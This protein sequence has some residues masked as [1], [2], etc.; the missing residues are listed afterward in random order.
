MTSNNYKNQLVKEAKQLD[1]L[2]GQGSKFDN[3]TRE[4]TDEQ[5]ERASLEL[6][7][8]LGIHVKKSIIPKI[9][10]RQN[11][12]IEL[13]YMYRGSK[14]IEELHQNLKEVS[15]I[16]LEDL[17]DELSEFIGLDNVKQQVRCLISFNKIQKLR[18]DN[19]LKKSEKTMHM[20]YLGNP[21][22]GKTSVARIIGKMYKSI[23]LLSKGH[24][25]E[26]SRTDL[27]AEYQGQTA[28]KVKR[29]IS[30]AKG[31]VLFI[32]EAYSITENDHS[33]SYGRECLT[34]LTKALEDYRDDLVV[35]VAGYTELME[36]FFN[37][38]P[39]IKSRFNTYIS[40]NDYSLDELV[41]IF[42]HFCK[43]NEYEADEKTIERVREWLE[44][45]LSPKDKNFANGRLVRNLYDDIIMN[46]SI[47]L[48]EKVGTISKET[49]K[50]LAESDVPRTKPCRS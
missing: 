24:F 5:N 12:I 11:K 14:G 42:R 6:I 2:I 19:G 46:Q 36:Q 21:G 13:L 48:S 45:K 3:L 10:D 9:E 44:S 15:N 33:D 23:G 49:L 28:I 32:D 40:F 35:I 16:P 30:R 8:E 27:I 18:V 7:R 34:E 38:N 43:V 39:G 29:L 47:R 22:T 4:I 41:D 17:L 20:A 25:I 26:A 50:A 1:V 31:G 37:S